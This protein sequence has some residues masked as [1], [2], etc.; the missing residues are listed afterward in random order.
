M[1]EAWLAL[2]C[3]KGMT[4]VPIKLLAGA[5]HPKARLRDV[6]PRLRCNTCRDRPAEVALIENPSA[7]GQGGPPM[8]W[9]IR[10]V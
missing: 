8:G 10:L 6:L 5:A 4:Y 9:V 1:G 2:T 3:C 7:L